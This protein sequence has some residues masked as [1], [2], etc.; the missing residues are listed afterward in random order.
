MHVVFSGR[1]SG[2]NSQMMNLYFICSIIGKFACSDPIQSKH[3]PHVC[4]SW[5]VA[6]RALY[7]WKELLFLLLLC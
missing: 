1:W 2:G 3:V 6:Y 4:S 7:E 5:Q